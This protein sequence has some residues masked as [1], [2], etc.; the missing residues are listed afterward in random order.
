MNHK[1]KCW[2]LHGHT[3]KLQVTV[4]SPHGMASGTGMVI[5]FKD[6]KQAINDV[7]AKFDHA[8]ILNQMDEHVLKF[9]EENGYA[10]YMID[11]EPTAENIALEIEVLLNQ[12]FILA[13]LPPLTIERLILWETPTSYAEV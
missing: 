1:F 13:Q 3:Y 8:M 2:N 7:V 11:G 10:L 4:S 9:C 5:D 6:L 12:Q